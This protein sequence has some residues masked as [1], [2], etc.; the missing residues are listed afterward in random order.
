ML[1]KK[2]KNIVDGKHNHAYGNVFP[3]YVSDILF[4]QQHVLGTS[5]TSIYLPV[6]IHHSTRFFPI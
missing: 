3:V 2:Y 4:V 5:P 6:W 1:G